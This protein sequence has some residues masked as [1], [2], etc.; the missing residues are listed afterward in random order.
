MIFVFL[1]ERL[2]I[3]PKICLKDKWVSAEL[4][5]TVPLRLIEDGKAI[6]DSLLAELLGSILFSLLFS[7]FRKDQ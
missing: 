4:S 5:K 2:S 7:G 1:K 6:L 3:T